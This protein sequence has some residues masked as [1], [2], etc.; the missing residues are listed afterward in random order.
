MTELE[1]VIDVMD[2]CVP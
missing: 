2:S 1:G